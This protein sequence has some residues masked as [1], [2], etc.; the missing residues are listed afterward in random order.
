[1]HQ[2]FELTDR[3]YQKLRAKIGTRIEFFNN[4]RSF[5]RIP[6]Y[7]DWYHFLTT[8]YDPGRLSALP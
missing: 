1:M 4:L 8:I 3:A 7:K 2:I 5:M 6:G